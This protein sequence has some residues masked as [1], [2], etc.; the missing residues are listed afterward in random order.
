MLMI[1]LI[2][3][4]L[5]IVEGLTEFIPVSSTGHLIIAGQLLNFTGPKAETFEIAIQAGAILAIVILYFSR[6]LSLLNFSS[7][8]GFNGLRGI[9]LLL[10]TSAPA[11]ILGLATHHLIKEYLF[12][13][14]PVAMALF[15]GGIA[16]LLIER[17]T[18]KATVKKLDQMNWKKALGVGLFQCLSL[19]PGTSRSASTILGGML[20][21]LDRKTAAEYSFLS[22]VP[23]MFAAT[24]FDLLKSMDVLS[25]SDIPMFAVGLLAAFVSALLAVK[26]FINWVSSKPLSVFGWY[27]IVL[28]VVVL[29]MWR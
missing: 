21:K 16:I 10:L 6:F 9:G 5:G 14:K 1:F 27:R 23:V 25:V 12:H 2:A 7:K 3:I 24:G 18:K 11:M 19:W 4:I 26:F 22:A 28:A 13:P 20:L 17:V 29:V 8:K 15:L